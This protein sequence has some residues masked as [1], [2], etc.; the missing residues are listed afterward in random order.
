MI[1]ISTEQGFKNIESWD[2]VI[3]NVGYKSNLD[4]SKHKLDSIIGR[5][6]EKEMVQCGLSNCHTK[7]GKGYLVK[8]QSGLSTNIGKDCGKK[9]FGVDFEIMAK[10]FERD[11]EAQNNREILA[12]FSINID[13]LEL[14]INEMRAGHNG[15]DYLYKKSRL[16]IT[17]GRELPDVVVTKIM[18]MVKLSSNVLIKEREATKEETDNALAINSKTRLPLYINEQVAT[19]NGLLI[20]QKDYD[21]RDILIIDLDQNINAFKELDIDVID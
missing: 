17:R 10:K 19:V 3:H 7:H 11:F 6:V 15:A 1:T 13:E 21:L 4:P 9:Y 5:Y 20:L 8:T 16:L 12:S 18:D 14:K 2:D